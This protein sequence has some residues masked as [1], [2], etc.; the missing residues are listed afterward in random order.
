LG[1]AKKIGGSSNFKPLNFSELFLAENARLGAAFEKGIRFK[2]K[3][4]DYPELF[5]AENARLGAAIEKGIRFKF[6]LLD[7]PELFL[8]ENA[9]LGAFSHHLR[10]NFLRRITANKLNKIK[11][12]KSTK[13]AAAV[14]SAKPIS[15]ESDHK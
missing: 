4:L 3:L 7:Y 10:S 14:F 12:P 11:K 2:F 15:G 6:K 1:A 9:R 8:A 5:L 13:I